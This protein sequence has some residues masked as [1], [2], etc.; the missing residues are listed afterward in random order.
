MPV[1]TPGLQAEVDALYPEGPVAPP[2]QR[3]DD[4]ERRL[5][6]L[7]ARMEQ[8]TVL[9]GEIIGQLSQLAAMTAQPRV[10]EVVRD[11]TGRI[12]AVVESMA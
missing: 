12:T 9:L 5:A 1:L 2:K 10:R 6:E 4:L 3:E 8:M 11:A 7:G